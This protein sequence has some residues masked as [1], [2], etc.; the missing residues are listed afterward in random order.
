MN[1]I[2]SLE[3]DMNFDGNDRLGLNFI[4]M[5]LDRKKV[6][7]FRWRPTIMKIKKQLLFVTVSN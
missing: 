7:N 3:F 1:P 5:I 2:R 4:T 6:A